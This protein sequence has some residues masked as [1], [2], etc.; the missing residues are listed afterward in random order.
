MSTWVQKTRKKAAH[1]EIARNV[2]GMW[3]RTAHSTGYGRKETV[4]SQK[5]KTD[6]RRLLWF[7]HCV[8]VCAR[9]LLKAPYTERYVRCCERTG[10][11]HPLLLDYW[12]L[13]AY[14][15]S[16]YNKQAATVNCHNNDFNTI[17]EQIWQL[18]QIFCLKSKFTP[19]IHP[20]NQRD[21]RDCLCIITKLLKFAH[22]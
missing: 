4:Q 13:D 12:L 20:L 18:A 16:M 22:L 17:N 14:K 1:K 19:C 6:T 11:S 21:S 5:R 10:V 3:E 8:S 2:K 9:Q 15:I 7:S